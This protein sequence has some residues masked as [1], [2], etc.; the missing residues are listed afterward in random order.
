M[1]FYS[2]LEAVQYFTQADPYYY[3]VDNRPL[4]NLANRDVQLA[5]ELD[6]RTLA[7]DITGAASPTVNHVPAGWTVGVNGTGDYTITH[8]LGSTSYI[9]Q[10]TVVDVAG[11][12]GDVHTLA[13]NTIR[14]VIRTTAGA[15]AHKRFQLLITGY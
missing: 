6:R 1:A 14:V 2:D 3:T 12:F 5:N 10:I 11:G 7:V 8:N 15:A 9:G 4:T 13:A